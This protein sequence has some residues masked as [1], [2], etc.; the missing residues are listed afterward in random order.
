MYVPCNIWDL[1]ILWKL[2]VYLKLKLNQVS[3]VLSGNQELSKT[4]MIYICM[5]SM[6]HILLGSKGMNYISSLVLVK[7]GKIDV[8]NR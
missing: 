1:I 3:C 7:Y 5:F 8:N 2:L 6:N 4:K